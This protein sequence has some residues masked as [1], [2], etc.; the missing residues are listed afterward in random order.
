MWSERFMAEAFGKLDNDRTEA[1]AVP[2]FL[3]TKSWER[4]LPGS[5]SVK[6]L[7]PPR[8]YR[9]GGLPFLGALWPM[10]RRLHLTN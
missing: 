8:H 10:K 2:D 4:H 9:L 7:R 6:V 5:V 3:S 1:F